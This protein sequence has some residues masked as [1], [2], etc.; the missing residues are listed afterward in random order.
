[1]TFYDFIMCIFRI[2]RIL[3]LS[4]GLLMF[5]AADVMA[6]QEPLLLT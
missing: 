2:D 3:S 6:Y 1:M 4:N 5:V